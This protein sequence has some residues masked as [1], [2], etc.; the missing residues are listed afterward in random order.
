MMVTSSV[1][2]LRQAKIPLMAAV[3]DSSGVPGNSS[4]VP[5][6]AGQLSGTQFQTS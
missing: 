1:S 4:G 2:E 3:G 6:Y 5:S